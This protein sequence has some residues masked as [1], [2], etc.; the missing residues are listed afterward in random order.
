MAGPPGM[1][2]R[3]Q[4]SAERM[5]LVILGGEPLD[6]LERWAAEL[7]SAAPAGRGPSPTF[8]DAGFPFEV[9]GRRRVGTGGQCRGV[10]VEALRK[11]WQSSNSCMQHALLSGMW[12]RLGVGGGCF[13]MAGIPR[14]ARAPKEIHAWFIKSPNHRPVLCPLW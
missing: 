10:F 14:L 1:C 6:T 9:R 12:L 3:G 2:R 4:Y 11:R 13:G 8:Y 5:N 7:F